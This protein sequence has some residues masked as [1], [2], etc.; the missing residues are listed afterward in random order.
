MRWGGS[1]V[2]AVMIGA[3]WC[4]WLGVGCP[5]PPSPA[6]PSGPIRE[7]SRPAAPALDPE[8]GDRVRVGP[9]AQMQVPKGWVSSPQRG[10]AL[11]W[12][13]GS[14][15]DVEADAA[16]M[17]VILGDAVGPGVSPQG[18]WD[19]QGAA[20]R[21][22]T[23]GA[24]DFLGEGAVTGLSL[25]AYGFDVSRQE[26]DRRWRLW[27]VV[28]LGEAHTYYLTFAVSAERFE[29]HEAIFRRALKTLHEGP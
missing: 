13:T 24:Q 27:Q 14:F 19:A 2:R 6:E 22:E 29:F 25:P 10:D 18:V 4:A 26:G 23:D 3:V 8:L 11:A 28:V 15:G 12:Q 20:Y 17:T 5:R 21:Q 1:R 16:V 9:R 7:L